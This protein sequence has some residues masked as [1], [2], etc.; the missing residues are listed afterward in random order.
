MVAVRLYQEACASL[1]L[2]L[3]HAM[4]ATTR[5]RYPASQPVV[6]RDTWRYIARGSWHPTGCRP[7]LRGPR[8]WRRPAAALRDR[9]IDTP[10]STGGWRAPVREARWPQGAEAVRA[11]KG[12]GRRSVSRRPPGAADGCPVG[13]PDLLS[14]RLAMLQRTQHRRDRPAPRADLLLRWSL[15]SAHPSPVWRCCNQRRRP[16]VGAAPRVRC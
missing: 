3:V 8:P 6:T 9:N 16:N 5:Q 10:C 11:A 15:G 1:R 2:P 14:T 12:A 4:R 7:R 13:I